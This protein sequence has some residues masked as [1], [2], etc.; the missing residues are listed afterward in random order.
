MYENLE[1]KA[2]KITVDF[3]TTGAC[4]SLI[5]RR[6]GGGERAPGTHCLRMRVI[7][8]KTRGRIRGVY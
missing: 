2:I 8:G 5:P 7:I 1:D 6:G 3:Y 4:I